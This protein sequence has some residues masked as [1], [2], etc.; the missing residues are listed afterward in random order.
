MTP[1]HPMAFVLLFALVAALLAG[2]AWSTSLR[3]RRQRAAS[4]ERLAQLERR[5]AEQR[6]AASRAEASRAAAEAELRASEER[7]AAA[8]RGSQDGMWDWD[9][10]SGCVELSPR[11]KSML[12]FE[13]HELADDL[14]GWRSRVHPD[15]RPAFERSLAQA[16]A[17]HAA[18]DDARFEHEMRMLHK[19]GSV[20]WVLS[21]G[22][23]LRRAGAPPYRMVGQDTDVT[24]IRRV[25][26]VL[27]AVA[28]GTAGAVGEAFFPAMVRHFARALGL[29]CVFVAECADQP[30]TRVRTLAYWAEGSLRDNF[31]FALAGTPCEAVV[32]GG[33]AC[34]HRSGLAR[35]FPREVGWEAY[36]GMP[37]VASDG[38]T[39]GHLAFFHRTP[40]GDEMLVDSV[41]RIFLARAAA[42]LERIQALARRPTGAS[43]A[44]AP[45]A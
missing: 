2:L 22:V 11:W 36:L 21:R 44:G 13:A 33:S 18:P 28:D 9:I 29:D 16:T 39:L 26:D 27:Q 37:I 7:C 43:P 19:D 15:D 24:P 8:L 17:A 30:A 41:Y 25:L 38:R 40:L 4:E 3:A 12:G 23:A 32:Q 20:R 35:M 5:L 42:E 6:A 10:G 14:A 1:Q 34:F 45:A 31:E